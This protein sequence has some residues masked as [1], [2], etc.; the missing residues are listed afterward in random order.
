MKMSEI[1]NLINEDKLNELGK[2]YKI[3]KV[4]HKITGLFIVKSFV[5]CILK[6]IKLSLRSLEMLINTNDNFS[7][8]LKAKNYALKK[9][10]HSSIGK[11]LSKI[12]TSFFKDIYEDLVFKYNKMFSDNNEIKFHI[13]DSTI[14]TLSGK[15]LKDGLN[16]G[17]KLKDRH[18][19]MSFS[20]KNKIPS[21]VRFCKTQSESSEDIALVQAINEK[22][23]KK[24]TY[25]CLIE[26][27]LMLKHI[28]N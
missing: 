5:E 25:Y 12:D 19:K 4:N 2:L 8:L 11:R 15:L 23:K 3:D 6:N 10:D 28:Q 9:F 22:N 27:Y 20:I 21:N 17:G 16:C 14:I 13:F 7:C 1:M 26:A 24:M 18:I